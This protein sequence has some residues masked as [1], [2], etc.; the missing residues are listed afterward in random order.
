MRIHAEHM[1]A[2][3]IRDLGNAR[4]DPPA[5]DD[6]HRFAVQQDRRRFKP[7]KIRLRRPCAL[8]H[9]SGMVFDVLAESQQQ[10]DRVLRDRFGA[11]R[12]NIGHNDPALPCRGG[13]N[14]V[15]A[16]RKHADEL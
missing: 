4:A 15:V 13:V 16:G 2:E 3:S 1:H 14:D 12:G 10:G 9:Q 8:M 5:A 7:G 6:P 11:V